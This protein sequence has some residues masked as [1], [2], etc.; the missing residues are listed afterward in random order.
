[1]NNNNQNSANEIIAKNKAMYENDNTSEKKYTAKKSGIEATAIAFPTTV[2]SQLLTT[3]Q[4]GNLINAFFRPLFRDYVGCNVYLGGP[5]YQN[6]NAMG[7]KGLVNSD[8]MTTMSGAPNSRYEVE[9]YFQRGANTSAAEGAISNIEDLGTVSSVDKETLSNKLAARISA[10]NAKA[11]PG[12]N[13]TL[14]KDTRDMLDEFFL[15]YYRK[16]VVVKEKNADGKE[17]KVTKSVPLYDERLIYEVTDGGSPMN[18]MG[19][20]VYLKLVGLDAIAL[21]RKIYGSTNELGHNV[22]YELKAVRPIP[23]NNGMA[24][25]NATNCLLQLSRLDCA[26]VDNICR[27]VGMMSVVSGLFINRAR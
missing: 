13:I 18:P 21:L 25:P 10:V 19:Y 26:E 4:L 22:D 17:V 24:Q 9:L 3:I 2:E 5:V 12:K 7:P 23:V 11:V 27:S 20:T 6:P 14:S 8:N 1:M 16:N 15:G